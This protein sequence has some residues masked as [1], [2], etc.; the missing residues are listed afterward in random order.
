MSGKSNVAWYLE[1]RGHEPTDDAI[2]AV[3]ELAKATPR[4][5]TEKEILSAAGV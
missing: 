2:L 5:L 4:M 3:L 1:K